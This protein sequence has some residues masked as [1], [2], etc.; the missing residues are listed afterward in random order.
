MDNTPKDNPKAPKK[1]A[2][3]KQICALICVV[4]LILMYLVTLLVAFFAPESSGHLITMCI[5]CTVALPMLL[6][7]YVWLY[8]KWKTRNDD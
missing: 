6:W 7:I 5:F 8:Q 4:L 3:L 1:K 2:T